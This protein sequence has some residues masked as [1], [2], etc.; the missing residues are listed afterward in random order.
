MIASTLRPALLGLLPVLAIA[1]PAGIV[2]SIPQERPP[3]EA[4]EPD[5][6]ETAVRVHYLEIVTPDVDATCNALAKLHA[7]TFADPAPE[8]GNARTAKLR[9]GGLVGVRAPMRPDEEPVVRPYVLV[10]DI[11]AAVGKAKTAGGEI[12]L[13]PT[14]IAGRGQCAIYFQGGIQHGLWEL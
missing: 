9:G 5:R 3:T 10:D 12:A 11:A 1:V 6:K 14:E 4:R 7:V 8:L 2:A 13:P